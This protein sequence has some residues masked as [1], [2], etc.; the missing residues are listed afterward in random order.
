QEAHQRHA[1]PAAGLPDDTEHLALG[2]LE[3]KPVDRL[4]DAVVGLEPDD[5]VVDRKQAHRVVRGSRTSRSPSPSRLNE[6]EQKK[7]AIPAFVSDGPRIAASPTATIRNGKASG[8]SV[9]RAIT[10]SIQ[11]R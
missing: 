10:G 2:E 11:P 9:S 4:H 5:E 1:L 7:I 3:R 6:S 8:T